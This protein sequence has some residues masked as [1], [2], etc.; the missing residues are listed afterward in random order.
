MTRIALLALA[1]AGLLAAP[2]ARAQTFDLAG[3]QQLFSGEP[4]VE[5]N[6]RGSLLRL[7]AEASRREEPEFASM[8]ENLQGIFV[9]Q[10]ALQD[11]RAGLA[12]RVRGFARSMEGDGWETLVRAREDD[13]GDVY[14]YLRPQGDLINGLVVMA[15][16]PAEGEATFVQ[17]V[18]R[19]DPAQIGRLGSR[20]GVDELEDAVGERDRDGG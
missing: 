2:G 8:V 19:I 4:K 13:G 15:L 1:L 20:F 5:V 9:R 12:D 7:V 3:I 17:I 16:D 18:G 11:A 14:V 10:F 6:L